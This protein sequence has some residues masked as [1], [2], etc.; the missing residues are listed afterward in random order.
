MFTR[1]E[2][3]GKKEATTREL[4]PY[5]IGS[6]P[7]KRDRPPILDVGAGPKTE[8]LTMPGGF[9]IRI[10]EENRDVLT[11][12]FFGPV[13]L[14]R[15]KK[16]EVSAYARSDIGDRP[17]LIVANHAED[18]I[19]RDAVLLEPM[20]GDRVR[21]T[22]LSTQVPIRFSDAAAKLE[23]SEAREVPLTVA[24]FL[25]KKTIRLTTTGLENEGKTLH[26]LSNATSPPGGLANST[27]RFG[28][29]VHG[30]KGELSQESVVRWLQV[31]MSVLQAAAG[32]TEFLQKAAKAVVDL[33]GLDA[34]RVLLFKENK[35]RE[36][37][38]F[39]TPRLPQ[40]QVQAP[41]R[42][43]LRKLLQ[44]KRTF[45]EV[46]EIL[47]GEAKS[48]DRVAAVVAAPIL[49]RKGEVVGALYGDRNIDATFNKI[50]GPITTAEATLVEVL[51]GT[52]AAGLERLAQE[53]RAVE[54]QVRFEQFFTPELAKELLDHPEMLESRE[55]EVTILFCDIREFSFISE[56]LSPAQTM[57]LVNDVMEALSDCVVAQ[58]G[59]LVDYIGDELIAMWGAP[60]NQP[61]HAKLG[62]SAAIAMLDKLPGL[63][64]KWHEKLPRPIDIGI[65]INTGWAG[66]GNTGT[67]RKF[68]YGPLGNA[69]NIA[70]RLQGLTRH[71]K[72]G[73]VVSG[74]TFSKLDGGFQAR[75]LGKVKVVNIDEPFEVY[76]LCPTS[77]PNWEPLRK[78]YEQAL[79]QFEAE[80][81]S[82]A[83]RKLGMLQLE[84]P[85]DG[86]S[87]ILL[88]RVVNAKVDPKTFNR[89][90][91][92]DNK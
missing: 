60:R 40:D 50:S 80:N 62:C 20:D 61:D 32:T 65:G 28:D 58:G 54:T 75:R 66:V 78:S 74:G 87:L 18:S 63:N 81:F 12:E 39:T 44:E 69:V 53:K 35:W 9:R 4:R 89:V 3:F 52:I 16:G 11:D 30:A 2:E 37:A 70:S 1:L 8:T 24:V 19:P 55:A 15:Q 27:T 92:R 79:E 82:L 10:Y 43:V 68:K 71:Y 83:A 73:L 22:N 67:K 88:A 31:T 76:E 29:L 25:G 21:L 72:A 5:N 7:K 23:P 36:E 38:C 51:A 47:P 33:V 64:E 90:W 41:S 45:F 84:F 91:I 14:G 59:V 13:V 49:D 6:I 26:A 42:F 86:P 46:P 48:L 57:E 56:K 34:G 85:N 17:R 77:M